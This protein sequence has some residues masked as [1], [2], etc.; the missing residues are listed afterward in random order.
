MIRFL[1]FA[2]VL[3]LLAGIGFNTA[4]AQPPDFTELVDKVSSAVV[5][6]EATRTAEAAMRQRG[7]HGQQPDEQEVPEIFRRFFGQPGGPG[8]RAPQPRDRTSMGSG[9]IISADGYVLTNHHVIDGADEV[10]VRLSDRR[11]LDAEVVGS[12]ARSDVAV[13][14]IKG[15]NLPTVDLGDSRNLKPGQWVVAI[16]SPFGFDHS[17]TAG[18]V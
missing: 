6:V 8:F 15:S 16:G 9:F 12:D 7:Q 3:P 18:I 5:N 4:N 11:E 10:V 14:K 13:L 1:K 2:A 17:V